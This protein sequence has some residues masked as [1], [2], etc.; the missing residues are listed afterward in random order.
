[1]D[2]S[3]EDCERKAAIMHARTMLVS[4][5]GR[6]VTR[7]QLCEPPRVGHLGPLYFRSL[8]LCLQSVQQGR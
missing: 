4:V 6:N 2:I 5:A 8:L 7:G 3:A 1:M